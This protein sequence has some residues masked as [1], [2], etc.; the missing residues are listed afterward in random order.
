M[1][2]NNPNQK[3]SHHSPLQTKIKNV[4]SEA[5]HEL[6][7][8]SY[9]FIPPP[10]AA[11]TQTQRLQ[12]NK[13]TT[14]DTTTT[15]T[16]ATT[17][18]DRMVQKYHDQLYKEYALA[19]FSRGPGKIG[20]RWR[21]EQEVKNGRGEM[22][23][24]NKHCPITDH[25]INQQLVTF[26]VPFAYEERGERK[27]ELVKIRLCLTC[28]SLMAKKDD[29]DGDKESRRPKN[30]EDKQGANHSD[31]SDSVSTSSSR[32]DNQR[33]HH[34]AKKDKEKRKRHHKRKRDR[35]EGHKKKRRKEKNMTMVANVKK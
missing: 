6:L 12:A 23:C 31:D 18:K 28:K 15:T 20:L 19:D 9:S 27:K 25:P 29:G 1:S 4:V 22:T 13:K 24:S 33:R 21:T 35:H 8:E 11:A 5:D 14:N 16:T 34:G 30:P 10:T 7:R 2:K 3:R 17:W 32:S 26:E